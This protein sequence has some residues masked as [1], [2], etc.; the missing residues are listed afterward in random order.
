M[1]KTTKDYKESRKSIS[2]ISKYQIS[3]IRKRITKSADL[4]V[5]SAED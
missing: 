1:N 4:V 3:N 5:R 2:N